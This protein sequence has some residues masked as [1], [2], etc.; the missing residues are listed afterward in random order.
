MAG[1]HAKIGV[2]E[3]RQRSCEKPRGGEQHG[4]ER[5]LRNDQYFAK[6]NVRAAGGNARTLIFQC[7]LQVEAGGAHRRSEAENHGGCARQA[8]GET[9]TREN[10]DRSA[11]HAFRN[12]KE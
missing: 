11:K 10:R 6:A 1:I 9:T 4:S 8:N 7:A 2:F 5:D 3:I 12:P